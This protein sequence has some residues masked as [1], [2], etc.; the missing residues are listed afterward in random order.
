MSRT[1]ST[2]PLCLQLPLRGSSLRRQDRGSLCG[3]RCRCHR[4][5]RPMYRSPVCHDRID[6]LQA[7]ARAMWRQ[8]ATWPKPCVRAGWQLRSKGDWACGMCPSDA[9]QKLLFVALTPQESGRKKP[10]TIWPLMV[11]TAMIRG[12]C[13]VKVNPKP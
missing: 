2:R 12:R 9:A 4:S 8:K 10:A 5:R 3:R 7:A 6:Q 13:W 1:V 11:I